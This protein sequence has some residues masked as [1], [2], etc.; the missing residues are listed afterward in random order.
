[1]NKKHNTKSLGRRD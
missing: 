1:M